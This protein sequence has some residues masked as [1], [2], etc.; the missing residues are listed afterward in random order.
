MN[1]LLKLAGGT[2]AL[3][4]LSGCGL[5][6]GG[7]AHVSG[8]IFTSYQAPGNIGSGAAGAKTG[9]ACAMSI[10]GLI[11]IGDASISAAKAAGG[12]QQVAHVDHANMT[13]LG[14]YGNTCT[15]VVGQ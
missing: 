15:K 9:E 14:L 1:K 6:S 11:G 7:F 8:G 13:I 4:I 3:V 5:A 12:I 10:L 2:A